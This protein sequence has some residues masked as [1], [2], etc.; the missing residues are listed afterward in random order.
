MHSYQVCDLKPFVVTNAQQYRSL[1]VQQVCS[2]CLYLEQQS[3]VLAPLNHTIHDQKG[4]HSRCPVNIA[5]FK[6]SCLFS[7]QK[8]MTTHLVSGEWQHAVA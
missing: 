2:V 7:V 3:A 5:L 4:T 1:L 8:D 6:R